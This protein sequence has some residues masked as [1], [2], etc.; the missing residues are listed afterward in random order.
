MYIVIESFEGEETV[1][2]S[3]SLERDA[4]I[5]AQGYYDGIVSKNNF[6]EMQ[7]QAEDYRYKAKIRYVG[8]RDETH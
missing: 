5:H 1:L 8:Y 2:G 4:K 7:M 3:H 6:S